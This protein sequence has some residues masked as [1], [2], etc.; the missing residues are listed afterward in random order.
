MLKYV[1][2]MYPYNGVLVRWFLF[3]VNTVLLHCEV[4]RYAK[5]AS[6]LF[7]KKVH[8]H[9]FPVHQIEL[10]QQRQIIVTST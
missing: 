1:E 9:D 5:E 10:N 2:K 4:N 7:V 8:F 6:N 3:Q